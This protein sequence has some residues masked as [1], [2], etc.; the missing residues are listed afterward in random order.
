MEAPTFSNN[1]NLNRLSNHLFKPSST[2][3]QFDDIDPDNNFFNDQNISNYY[4][5][6]EFTKKF[7]NNEFE[8]R[9]SCI[10]FNARSLQKNFESI[11]S[12]IQSLNFDF[13]VI[14]VTETWM[15]CV[16]PLIH[17][18]FYS[19]VFKPR[20]YKCGGINIFINNKCHYKIRDDLTP[21]TYFCE[22]QFIEV[23]TGKEDIIIG[24]IYRP[25]DISI[26]FFTQNFELLI[27]NLTKENNKI[28]L[29]GDFNIDLL[30]FESDNNINDFVHCLFNNSL[31][32][33][34]HRPTRIT[35][36]SATL[37]DNIFTND[38]ESSV[39]GII[40]N[41]ATDHL[42]VFNISSN[43]PNKRVINTNLKFRNT[44]EHNI[45]N[46]RNDLSI[47]PWNDVV[48]T[49]DTNLAYDTFINNFTTLY[50]KH[51]PL[52]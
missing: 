16:S 51:F 21:L 22:S 18:P 28:F 15:D 40:I 19:L 24:T 31:I 3:S 30:K 6:N 14:S 26:P 42:P 50:N 36:H 47:F 9:F 43:K 17:L 27:K 38:L 44:S 34:I 39:S 49:Q 2:A 4:L 33:L 48:S 41:D 12:C 8:N 45:L 37:I 46:F 13:D 5:P 7:N 32:S 11:S 52:F 1:D 10:H 23:K 29:L 20:S 35:E 25:H